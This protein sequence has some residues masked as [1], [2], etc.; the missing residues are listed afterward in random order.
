VPGFSQV[1]PDLIYTPDRERFVTIASAK[2][3]FVVIAAQRGLN[4]QAVGF[5]GRPVNSSY[6]SHRVVPCLIE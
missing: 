5:A 6:I 1:F 3:T 4:Y 2:S